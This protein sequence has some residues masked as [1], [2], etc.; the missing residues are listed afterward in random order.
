MCIGISV[1]ENR[2]PVNYF[3]TTVNTKFC[4]I[5]YRLAIFSMSN[6]EHLPNFGDYMVFVGGRKWYQSKCRLTFIFDFYTTHC[7]SMISSILHR[8]A[9]VQRNGRQSDIERRA[10]RSPV[11]S[12]EGP[13][14]PTM[15]VGGPVIG[16]FCGCH[17]RSLFR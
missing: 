1:V 9:I 13:G 15:S 17:R 14:P 16:I 12:A 5:C 8:L 11:Q 6:S 3:P 10:K 7:M 2:K 4:F